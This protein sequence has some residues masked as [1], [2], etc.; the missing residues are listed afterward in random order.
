VTSTVISDEIA[1]VVDRHG[2][3]GPITAEHIMIV[4]DSGSGKSTLHRWVCAESDV[5]ALIAKDSS[6]PGRRVTDR[7][8]AR[9]AVMRGEDV[10]VDVGGDD[11]TAAVIMGVARSVP[12]PVI[13]S[14]PESSNYLYEPDDEPAR[15]HNPVWWGLTEGRDMG[16]KVVGDTQHPHDIPRKPLGQVPWIAWCGI[17][18]GDHETFLD[19]GSYKWI[20]QGDL[21]DRELSYVVFSKKGER[22]FPE[23]GYEDTP[24]DYG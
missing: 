14:F 9:S 24:E 17:P 20:P 23:E 21:P 13:T 1:A 6:F 15:R 4:G 3:G 11:K 10:V 19:Q 16:I 7:D 12:I 8:A 2:D 5:P 22:A 18:H